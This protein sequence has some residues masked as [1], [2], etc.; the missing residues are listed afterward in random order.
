M[1]MKDFCFANWTTSHQVLSPKSF[2]HFAFQEQ[3]FVYRSGF[4]LRGPLALR[5]VLRPV[6][7]RRLPGFA[8]PA[9]SPAAIADVGFLLSEERHMTGN[10]MT[11]F[12]WFFNMN[13]FYRDNHLHK[14]F[15]QPSTKTCIEL[16][17]AHHIRPSTV[18]CFNPAKWY[19]SG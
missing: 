4:V 9:F 19:R 5:S 15:W 2:Q 13:F 12:F 8:A 18:F 3:G 16:A 10:R 7:V 17:A 6:S 11:G 14:A 1:R